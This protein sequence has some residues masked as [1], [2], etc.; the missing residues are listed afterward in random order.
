MHPHIHVPYRYSFVT[1]K[2]IKHRA[3]TQRFTKEWFNCRVPTRLQVRLGIIIKT[4][5]ANMHMQ[6]A[7]GYHLERTLH[8]KKNSP[9]FNESL[10]SKGVA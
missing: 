8:R 6:D 2:C 4:V 5:L 3:D 1:Q 7:Y 10:A 9:L